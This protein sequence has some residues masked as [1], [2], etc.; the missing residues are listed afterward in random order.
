MGPVKTT[1]DGEAVGAAVWELGVHTSNIPA[2]TLNY[3][4]TTFPLCNAKPDMHST[5]QSQS[6]YSFKQK[7]GC[8]VCAKSAQLFM[9][10][11]LDIVH[12]HGWE[13]QSSFVC[14]CFQCLVCFV[15]L[16]DSLCVVCGS[17]SAAVFYIFLL[18]L[19]AV[20]YLCVCVCESLQQCV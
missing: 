4:T 8:L 12:L 6:R 3:S 15:L 5:L 11:G 18:L 13:I 19:F 17:G 20:V 1:R 9:S 16:L 10:N 7:L 14:L 2:P